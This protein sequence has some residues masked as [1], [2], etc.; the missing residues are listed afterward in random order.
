M[1]DILKSKQV[2][3]KHVLKRLEQRLSDDHKFRYPE[4]LRSYAKEHGYPG[5]ASLIAIEYWFYEKSTNDIARMLGMD[6]NFAVLHFLHKKSEQFNKT[7]QLRG[8][9]G[10]NNS[11]V[12]GLKEEIENSKTERGNGYA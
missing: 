7:L 9:G 4:L 8:K 12:K 10:S 6:T 3:G 11:N 2:I 5:P 1:S